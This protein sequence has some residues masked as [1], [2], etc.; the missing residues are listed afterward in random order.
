MENLPANIDPANLIYLL[1]L[2]IGV[3][4]F[5]FGDFR[6]K[7]GRNLQSAAIWVLIFMSAIVLYG[8][9]DNIEGQLF[10]RT[11]VQQI[12]DEIILT[13][14]GD[15]HFYATLTVNDADITFVVDTG[16]TNVVISRDD[17]FRI[18]FDPD[19]LAYTGRAR[20]A[21]GTVETA[22]VRLDEVIFADRTDRNLRASVNRG[23]LDT[24][25][26]GMSYL[27]RFAT[28]QISGNEMRLIP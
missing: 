2:L 5:I 28:I 15:G 23:I 18:G 10:P 17:A 21:N 4:S 13:R 3:G 20:T 8:F 16:A 12:G 22:D 26:L 14:A 6:N 19:D 7:L 27:N 1:I 25:L 24:S 11:S 9:K